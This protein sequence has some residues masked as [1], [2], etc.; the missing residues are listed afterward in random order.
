MNKAK[1]TKLKKKQR[2]Q[3]WQEKSEK[4]WND[5]P[6]QTT[7]LGSLIPLFSRIK[8]TIKIPNNQH[9]VVVDR[10]IKPKKNKKFHIQ[11]ARVKT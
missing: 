7:M 4:N 5:L 1:R 2:Q 6:S 3:R 10:R 11:A 9:S 8:I